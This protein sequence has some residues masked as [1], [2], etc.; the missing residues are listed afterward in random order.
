[1]TTLASLFNLAG[2]DLLIIAFILVLL[3]G[4][5]K[6]PELAKGLGQAVR[7]FNKAKNDFQGEITN[8]KP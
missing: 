8:P 7:E 6:L 5:K 3:F 1:M 2:P 4:A